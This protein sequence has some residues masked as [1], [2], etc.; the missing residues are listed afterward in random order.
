M[1]IDKKALIAQIAENVRVAPVE[2]GSPCIIKEV[3][4]HSL[5]GQGTTNFGK[6]L[7]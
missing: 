4:L 5:A 1:S 7:A 2:E 6:L 3:M